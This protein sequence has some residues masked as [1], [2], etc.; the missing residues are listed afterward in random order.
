MFLFQFFITMQILLIWCLIAIVTGF[1]VY[2]PLYL[3]C[4]KYK[5]VKRIKSLITNLLLWNILPLIIS[6][7]T[8]FM[9]HD[10][11]KEWDY[12]LYDPI[13]LSILSTLLASTII[14]LWVRRLFGEDVKDSK[15]GGYQQAWYMFILFWTIFL[16][17]PITYYIFQ[18]CLANA[19]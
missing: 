10:N 12:L 9:T 7:V 15:E 5:Q 18:L 1:L 14:F 17:I 13:M 2:P 11:M 19:Q 6:F 4:K 16:A 3:L 8:L